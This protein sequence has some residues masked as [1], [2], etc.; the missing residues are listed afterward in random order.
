MREGRIIQIEQWAEDRGLLIDSP[1]YKGYAYKYH[2]IQAQTMKL[3]EEVVETVI[4]IDY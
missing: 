4:A 1:E 2:D 3:M